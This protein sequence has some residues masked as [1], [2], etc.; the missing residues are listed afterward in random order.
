MS[1]SDAYNMER[2][3]VNDDSAFDIEYCM[4]EENDES[5]KEKLSF[6]SPIHI[7]HKKIEH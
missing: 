1:R 4:K 2:K 7:S 5:S 3:I 6:N